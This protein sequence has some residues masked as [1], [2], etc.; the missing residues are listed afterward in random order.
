MIRRLKALAR[1]LRKNGTT[2]ERLL[3]G[4][5][6]AKQLAGYKFRRQEPIGKYIV[7]FVCYSRWLIVE[8]DGGHHADKTHKVKD[9]ERDAWFSEQ[10]FRVMRLWNNEVIENLEGVLKAIVGELEVSPSP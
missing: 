3:W 5:L 4:S 1:G 2:A 6:R 7:D 10:G 9:D 8:V